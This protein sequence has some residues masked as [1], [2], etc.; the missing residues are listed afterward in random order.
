MRWLDRI[1]DWL[2]A[3]SGRARRWH[4][5][6]QLARGEAEWQALMREF[7]F[8]ERRKRALIAQPHYPKNP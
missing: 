5:R 4:N 6:K 2:H 1:A 8:A 7:G 3:L